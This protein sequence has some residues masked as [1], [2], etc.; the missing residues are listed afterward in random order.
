MARNLEKIK[1]IVIVMLENRS[2]DHMLGYLSLP[3]F[4]GADVEGFRDNTTGYDRGANSYKG[5][6]FIPW[7]CDDPFSKLPGDPPHE[8][9]N[10]SL[11]LGPRVGGKNVMD[12]L[13][14]R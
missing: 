10:I 4:R 1:T 13:V 9:D 7:L 11:Q 8:R 3:D 14:V 5:R 12:R 2:F 6:T